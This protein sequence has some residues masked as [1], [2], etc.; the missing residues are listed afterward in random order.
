MQSQRTP[1]VRAAAPSVRR[2]AVG[3]VRWL[4]WTLA[5]A[6]AVAR[7]QDSARVTEDAGSA[8]LLGAAPLGAAPLGRSP[9]LHPAVLHALWDV[10]QYGDIGATFTAAAPVAS[11]NPPIMAL[12]G[13]RAP[14]WVFVHDPRRDRW[15]SW[16]ILQHG[17]WEPRLTSRMHDVVLA[18]KRLWPV[19]NFA[20]L[21]VGAN[22]GW[23]S[24]N[25][26][27]LGLA[28]A[29]IEASEFNADLLRRSTI[30]NGWAAGGSFTSA[31]PRWCVPVFGGRAGGRGPERAG[32]G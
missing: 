15:M 28:T 2:Y 32:G 23:W 6:W 14:F 1:H 30:A 27:T 24:L 3:A 17:F 21:D 5:V 25:M 26:M 31:T 20:G 16:T 11:R 22:L 4:L 19:E 7:V 29:A 18:A 9:L 13:G 12:A 8:V 10:H